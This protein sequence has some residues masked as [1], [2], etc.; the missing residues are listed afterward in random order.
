[1]LNENLTEYAGMPVRDYEP[2][3]GLKNA[4][5]VAYRVRIGWEESDEGV[6]WV[7]RFADLLKDPGAKQLKAFIVGAWED[8]SSNDTT[9]IIEALAAARDTLVS[10]KH[11]FFG[12]IISEECEISWINHGD[13]SPILEAYPG[14]EDLT[15]RGGTG[16]S[17]GRAR[18]QNLKSLTIQTGGLP[19]SVIHDVANADFPN[20]EHLE[21]W[22]GEPNYGGDATVE[23]LAPLLSGAKFPRLKY[24]GLKDSVIEDEIAGVVANAPIVSRLETLDLSLGQLGDDGARALLSSPA[25]RKL[26]R[27]DLHYHFISDELV[28]QLQSMGIEV[29][30]SEKQEESRWGRFI[31]VS[32]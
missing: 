24:L 22:L 10:L 23:D 29:D 13:F 19:P 2:E 31:A 26:K 25:I 15:I 18:H 21:L 30:V 12:D 7:D 8:T 17:L 3:K 28:K 1:V 5:G 14:L 6:A 11:L 9:S 16:L 4:S 32:E 27:L 20:L